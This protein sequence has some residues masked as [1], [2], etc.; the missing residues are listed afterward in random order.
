MKAKQIPEVLRKQLQKAGQ[1]RAAM[2]TSEDRAK[3]GRKGWQ[4]RIK[5]ASKPQHRM[6]ND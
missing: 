1:R 6:S 4:T 2:M 3:Y 5:N